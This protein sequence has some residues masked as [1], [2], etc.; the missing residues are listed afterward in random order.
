MITSI[1][2]VNEQGGKLMLNGSDKQESYRR[3]MDAEREE[4]QQATQRFIRSMFLTGVSLALLPVNRLPPKPRQHFHAAGREFT[5]GL[6]TLVHG[7]AD[8]IEEMAKDTNPSTTLGDGPH[9]DGE[10]D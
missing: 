8:G 7:L 10:S 2:Y 5:H 4:L 6:A 1:H 9:T 3:S